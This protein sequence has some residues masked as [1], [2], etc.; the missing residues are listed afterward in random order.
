MRALFC[1][2]KSRLIVSFRFLVIEGNT[3]EIRERHKAGYGRTPGETYGDV[4][5]SL[6]PGSIIDIAT[7]ADEGSN[8]PDAM[9]LEGYDG[10]AITGSSLHLWEQKPE[11]MRQVELAR[12]VYKSRTPFFGSCWGLQV[13]AVAAGGD[14]QMNGKGREVCISRNLSPT[15]AGA[16]HPLLR[17]RPS[18]YDAPC[19]HLDIVTIPPGEMDVLA[20][21]SNTPVQAAEFRSQGGIFW[22]VQYHPEFDLKTLGVIMKRY[23]PILLAEGKAKDEAQAA[24]F[25]EDLLALY[26]D[27]SL[28]HVAWRYGI[29]E[30]ILDDE[31]RLTEIRNFV[32]L[33]VKPVKSARG[34]A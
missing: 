5:T 7:P 29:G 28:T 14:V 4:L 17:G 20:S 27:R 1:D 33:R 24:E 9:G 22:G 31:R 6:A 34:R 12:E 2:H 23:A 21:N 15:K 8:L 32:E 13:A 19:V 25:A 10:V 11:A 26:A 16:K 30:D 18:A 3:R